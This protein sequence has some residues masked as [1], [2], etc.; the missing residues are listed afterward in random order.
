MERLI[1]SDRGQITLPA[2]LRKKLGI[3]GGDLLIAEERPGELVLRPAAVVELEV[4]SDEQV[5]AWDEE[6]RLSEAERS[7]IRA[8]VKARK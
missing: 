5:A 8:R 7:E 3:R 6:D 2:S 1:V 4:W